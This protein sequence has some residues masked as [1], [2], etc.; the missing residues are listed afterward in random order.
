MDKL[1]EELYNTVMGYLEAEGLCEY[2]D[3]E[4]YYCD[5]VCDYCKMAKAFQ[6]IYERFCKGGE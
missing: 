4:E 3:D 6:A 2:A 1:Y 5:P